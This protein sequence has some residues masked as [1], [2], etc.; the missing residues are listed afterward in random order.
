MCRND[1]IVPA[2]TIQLVESGCAGRHLVFMRF[3][4]NSTVL[5]SLLDRWLFEGSGEV[6]GLNRF[7]GWE[8]GGEAKLGWSLDHVNLM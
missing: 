3:P 6:G 2:P 7:E 1:D 5:S 4:V 8:D